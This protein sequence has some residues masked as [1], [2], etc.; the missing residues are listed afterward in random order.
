MPEKKKP[1]V[2]TELLPEGPGRGALVPWLGYKGNSRCR[3]HWDHSQQ[4]RMCSEK[5]HC[6]GRVGEKPQS[7]QIKPG[8]QLATAQTWHITNMSMLHC[9][10]YDKTRETPM[11]F[12]AV[13]TIRCRILQF[14]DLQLPILDSDA[15]IEDPLHDAYIKC[16]WE[17]GL[18]VSVQKMDSLII[19]LIIKETLKNQQCEQL[20]T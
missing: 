12:S 13:F 17:C 5:G 19:N 20:S 18:V 10:V 9:K 11:M 16:R 14:D 15:T 2:Y 3:L 6:F 8:G 7:Q 4:A 1:G